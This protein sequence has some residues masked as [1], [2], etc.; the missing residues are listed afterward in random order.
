MKLVFADNWKEIGNEPWEIVERKGLGHPDSLAD[1]LAEAVS[2][3]YSN[4]CLGKFGC[5][6]HHN[7]D[8]LYIGAGLYKVSYGENHIL[9]PA[10]IRVNGRIRNSFFGQEIDLVELQR[11]SIRKCIIS[12]SSMRPILTTSSRPRERLVLFHMLRARTP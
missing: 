2:L 1:G 8:K 10:V 12:S 7:V 9:K 11:K 5:I 4:Y 3:D 6:P